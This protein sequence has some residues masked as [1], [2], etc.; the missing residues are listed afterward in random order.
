MGD[1]HRRDYPPPPL[2]PAS[3]RPSVFAKYCFTQHFTHFL[4]LQTTTYLEKKMA[5]AP[6]AWY[7]QL[8]NGWHHSPPPPSPPPSIWRSEENWQEKNLHLNWI[9]NKKVEEWDKRRK[10]VRFRNNE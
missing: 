7:L 6:S 1:F 10:D 8:D 3:G 2:P 4:P 5:S 9:E